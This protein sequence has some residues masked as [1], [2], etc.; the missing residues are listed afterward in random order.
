M[1][2]LHTFPAAVLL[3]LVAAA[4]TQTGSLRTPARGQGIPV[5]IE[6][7]TAEW[8]RRAEPFGISGA[9]AMLRDTTV[10]LAAGFGSLGPDGGRIG[11]DT[12][13]ILASLSKQFAAA[14]ILRSA[15]DGHLLLSDSLGRFFPEAPSPQRAIT[16]QQLLTHTS[17]MIYLEPHMFD[18][19]PDRTAL[20][21]ELMALPLDVAPGTRYSYSNPGY[22]V[23][24]GVLER[25]EGRAFESV[26][27]DRI[28][29]PA[30]MTATTYLGRAVS[31][32]PHGF[33]LGVDQGPMSDIPGADRAVGNGS[34]ISTVRD[35]ARW[36]VALRTNRILDRRW[37][38]ELF[39]PRVPAAAG[40][41]YAFGWNV[42][43][44]PR[45]TTVILHAGD[46]GPVRRLRSDD[47]AH[48]AHHVR[49]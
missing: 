43:P 11:P 9:I 49:G 40:A 31:G 32:A 24:A 27:A 34:I 42:L 1:R 8:L 12:P 23:L 7:R 17:G 6:S 15:A 14:A 25:A 10:T 20:M 38:T 19:A 13:F 30:G 46:L 41:Q 5:D 48:L 21:R 22:A 35:L 44:T 37:T 2:R 4:P 45:G 33:Q 26:M 47:N 28:F 29:R 16:L 3:S 36:E 18:P 39:T